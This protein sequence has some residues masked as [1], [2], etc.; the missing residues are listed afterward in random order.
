[1]SHRRPVCDRRPGVARSL[2]WLVLAPLLALAPL[3]EAAAGH[4]APGEG[5]SLH[6][7]SDRAGPARTRLSPQVRQELEDLMLCYGEG[8]DAIGD[9]TRDDPLADGRAVYSRCFTKDAVFRVWFPGT[10]FDGPP[11]VPP[12][13]G[14][15]AWAEFVFGAFD[16]TYTFTQHILTNF[17][18]EVRGDEATL[19]SYLNATHVVQDEGVVTQVDV[20]N[21][22]Y[23]LSIR[24]VRGRY[25]IE[26][27]DLKLLDFNPF[28]P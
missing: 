12:V 2:P 21:G 18:F 19:Q 22:T 24:K 6:G 20:A 4:P 26:A 28:F 14:P 7:E 17:R 27:L 9:S 13:D 25:R 1:M 3:P 10:P 5:A 23:T 11:T 8:T 15:D 16:G